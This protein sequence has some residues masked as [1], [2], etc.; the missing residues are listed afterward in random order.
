M[1]HALV[2][3][4]AI[5]FASL[6]CSPAWSE[7]ASGPQPAKVGRGPSVPA[8]RATTAGTPR[9]GIE[10]PRADYYAYA[11][12]LYPWASGALYRLYTVP[13][14]VSDIALQP[15][16]ALISV[17]AGDTARW[18]IGDTASGPVASKQVHVLV[19]PSVAG[20]S[21][22]LVIATDRRVYRVELSSRPA[23]EMAGIAWTYPADELLA[24]RR[25]EAASAAA[26]PV[27]AV[28]VELLDFSYAISGDRPS[29]RPVRAFDD[30]RRVFIQFPAGFE[31]GEAPPL[32]LLGEGD[33]AELVNYRQQ[34]L[35]YVVDRLF[36]A[37]ELRLGGRRQQ[38]VRITRTAPTRQGDSR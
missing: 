15:G 20:L 6:D 7:A 32:F 1:K 14:K 8:A 17:A 31:Q 30:G 35:Y 24:L 33:R 2:L 5:A 27:A 21:T 38:I 13:G 25:A 28:P 34:G 36:H 4:V 18:V 3:G 22:N 10:E 12:Q 19:K 16:E 9:R 23:R 37:A 26:Q 29:W 11:V